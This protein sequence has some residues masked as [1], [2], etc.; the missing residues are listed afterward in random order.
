MSS[1]FVGNNF[2]TRAERFI[3]ANGL[4]QFAGELARRTGIA[5]RRQ[6]LA[7]KL[8]CPDIVIG[9]RCYLRGLDCM[10]IGKGFQAD[11]G[12]WLEAV[13]AH[14]DQT[15]S[16][17]IIIG[18]DVSIS[19]WCHI[20]AT[21]RIEIGDGVLIGSKVLITDHNHGRF[22]EE[23]WDVA[24][25]PSLRPLD[26]DKAVSIGNNAW[27]GDGVFVAPGAT[28]GEG[29]VIGANSV[30]TGAIPPYTVA[31]GTPA[32]VLRTRNSGTI[33]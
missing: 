26:A 29:A 15:F 28:V 20:A 8:A 21:N 5:I 2:V 6:M 10:R 30:V 7:R 11:E 1:R 31:A 18:N 4:Y 33:S 9:P 24:L 19:R 25:P 27:I 17:R 22:G 14:L 32:R 23:N 13:I 16:P 3:R 12:L